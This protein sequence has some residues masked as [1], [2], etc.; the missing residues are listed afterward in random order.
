MHFN[1]LFNL[2]AFRFYRLKWS[3]QFPVGRLLL[4]SAVPLA[5]RRDMDTD[6][7]G[8]VLGREVLARDMVMVEATPTR[9]PIPATIILGEPT[10]V[11]VIQAACQMVRIP[12]VHLRKL[13]LVTVKIPARLHARS[14]LLRAALLLLHM[15]GQSTLRQKATCTTTTVSLELASGN[16]LWNLTTHCQTE[17]VDKSYARRCKT[18]PCDIGQVG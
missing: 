3:L 2:D 9:K 13:R 18:N 17:C 7:P 6:N 10:L 16:A 11:S 15:A 4:H 5:A 8:G 14:R 12:T 1:Y